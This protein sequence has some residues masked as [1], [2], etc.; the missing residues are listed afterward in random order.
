MKKSYG[1]TF[2]RS[3]M[4]ALLPLFILSGS[5]SASAMI[6]SGCP[7]FF[8]QYPI[9][10]STIIVQTGSVTGQSFPTASACQTVCNP[11]YSSAT[12]QFN[13]QWTNA[14]NQCHAVAQGQ[15]TTNYKL[16]PSLLQHAQPLPYCTLSTGGGYSGTCGSENYV[17][18]VY[19]CVS[20]STTT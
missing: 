2:F 7:Q 15:G 16:V 10:T 3:L 18:Q 9:Q 20:T 5:G 19:C 14:L 6:I 13:T 4:L 8:Q 1:Q 11:I 12:A 17:E